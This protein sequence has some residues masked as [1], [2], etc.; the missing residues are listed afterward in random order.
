MR[1][2]CSTFSVNG[3]LHDGPLPINHE[4]FQSSAFLGAHMLRR[5]KTE[6][7][8]NLVSKTEEVLELQFDDAEEDVYKAFQ[9]HARSRFNRFVR[10]GTAKKNYAHILVLLLR[11]RQIC[12]HPFLALCLS[13]GDP[14]GESQQS[15]AQSEH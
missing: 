8:D 4:Q 5:L 9:N 10:A 3:Q 13:D 14:A 11:L 7:V 12:D 6:V 15:D 2:S 1:P